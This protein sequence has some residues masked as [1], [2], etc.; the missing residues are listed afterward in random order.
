MKENLK[1]WNHYGVVLTIIISSKIPEVKSEHYLGF[2][3]DRV[4]FDV[5][6]KGTTF[7]CPAYIFCPFFFSFSF[8][9]VG[10]GRS[11]GL[12]KI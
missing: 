1:G 10:F 12:P 11:G 8:L 6:E 4:T 7:C 3:D 5:L 9:Q 2:P